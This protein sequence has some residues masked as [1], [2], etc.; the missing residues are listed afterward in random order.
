[1]CTGENWGPQALWDALGNVPVDDEGF[2]QEP[3]LELFPVGTDREDIWHWIENKFDIP[4][5]D[6]MFPEEG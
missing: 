4:V 2:L 5:H 3:F 6:L 1:V